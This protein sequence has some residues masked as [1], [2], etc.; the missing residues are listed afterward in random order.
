[1]GWKHG[2]T[3]RPICRSRGVDF[4]SSLLVRV[5]LNA[6]IRDAQAQLQRVEEQIATRT[7]EL[8]S[9]RRLN[10]LS[11]DPSSS[12][13]VI[14]NRAEVGRIDSYVRA[15]DSVEARL[16]IVDSV[17]NEVITQLTGGL[18]AVIG[19]RGSEVQP[20]ARE[21][22]AIELEGIR[23]TILAD[24]N[25]QFNGTYLFSGAASTTEP[26][27][28]TGGVVSAYQG[29]TTDVQIDID[30][31]TA[32]QVS[33]NGDELLRGIDVND[34]FVELDLLIT[35][36]RAGDATGMDTGTAALNRAFDRATAL[37]SQVGI[38]LR[39]TLEQRAQLGARRVEGV[40][41]VS[42]NEDAN[43]VESIS[44]LQSAEATYQ[45]AIRAIAVRLP[46]SLMD[47]IR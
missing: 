18:T 37:Q 27:T 34:L 24:V 47:F 5:P 32:V 40:K 38:D 45:A 14:V 43:L 26:Y 10:A 19:A 16:S 9:G 31:S 17:L 33:Q 21:A 23:D 42:R 11:D 15:T 39:T 12:A 4:F 20:Q 44:G 1:M 22:Y 46:L 2:S 25:M 30:R 35:A 6:A 3:R 41:R 8:S 29:S 13:S 28:K 7:R 36:V